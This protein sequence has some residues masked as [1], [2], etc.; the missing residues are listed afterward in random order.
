MTVLL[1]VVRQMLG[2]K[3]VASIA[4]IHDALGHVDP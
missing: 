3:Y 1:E 2:Q 4:A